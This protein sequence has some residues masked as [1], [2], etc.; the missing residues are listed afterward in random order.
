MEGMHGWT[1]SATQVHKSKQST[2]SY[3]RTLK[4]AMDG[5]AK[6]NTLYNRDAETYPLWLGAGI[7]F[8]N[9]NRMFLL[10]REFKTKVTI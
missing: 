1:E 10:I 6:S 3:W 4:Y 8:G 5:S 7:H 2:Q 9:K